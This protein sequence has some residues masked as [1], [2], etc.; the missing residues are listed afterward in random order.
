MIP[1]AY[2]MRIHLEFYFIRAAAVE[3]RIF[4]VQPRY[5]VLHRLCEPIYRGRYHAQLFPPSPYFG[6]ML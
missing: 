4:F 2:A 6:K 3:R 5:L 1:G